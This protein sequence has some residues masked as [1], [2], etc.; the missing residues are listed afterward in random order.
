MSDTQPGVLGLAKAQLEIVRPEVPDPIIP[1]RFNPTQYVLRK[2]NKYEEVKVPGLESPTLQFVSGG[3]EKLSLE[4]LLDTSDTLED[5]RE[6]YTNKLRDL[7]KINKELHAPPVVRFVWDTQVF[8]GVIDSMDFT[9]LIFSQ[10]GVPLRSKV[11]LSLTEYRPV[12]QQEKETQ[13][14]SP[15]VEK[16]YTVRRGDTLSSIAGVAYKDPAKWRDVAKENGIADPRSL[17]PGHVLILPRLR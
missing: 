7:M 15:D 17:D 3:P 11:N 1:L 14:N 16:I 12:E 10:E 5:V 6:R 9:F 8:V 2:T 4:V 13:K